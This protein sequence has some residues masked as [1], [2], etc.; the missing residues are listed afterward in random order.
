MKKTLFLIILLLLLLTLSGC[1]NS[2]AFGESSQQVEL[3]NPMIENQA[4][5]SVIHDN[6]ME[7]NKIDINNFAPIHENEQYDVFEIPV[8]TNTQTIYGQF[9]L[10]KQSIETFP[11]VV[12]SHGF[13][14]SYLYLYDYAAYFA[15]HG[16][17]AYIFDFCDGGLASQSSGTLLEMSILTE[18]QDLDAVIEFVQKLSCV[19]SDN[20]FLAGESQGGVVSALSAAQQSEKINSLILLYPAFVIPDDAQKVYDQYG[21]FPD[22]YNIFGIMVGKRYLEDA[23][24]KDIYEEIGFYKGDVLIIHGEQDNIVPVSYSYTALNS[25]EN[26]SLQVIPD[27]GH[28]FYGTASSAAA[29]MMVEFIEE[30]IVK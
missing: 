11:T 14:G 26:A 8:I 25:Y 10:P 22:Q 28:G 1:S 9:F 18:Q 29:N 23:T 17:A 19:D 27:A 12:F 16:I 5:Q 24:S 30:H 3:S 7:D 6:T 13:G 15:Q 4:S 21:Y 2:S 20:L